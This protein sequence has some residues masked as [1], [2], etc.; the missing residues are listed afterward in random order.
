[1]PSNRTLSAVYDG[2]A[3][4][5]VRRIGI[6]DLKVALS[7]GLDDFRAKPTHMAFLCII[8]PVV[9][10]FIA[11]AVISYQSAAPLMFPIAAG[12]ALIGPLAALGLYELSRRREQGLDAG[13]SRAFDVLHSP[14]IGAIFA[15]SVLLLAL[16]VGWLYAA[17][18]IYRICFAGIQPDSLGQFVSDIFTTANGWMLIVVGNGVGFVFAVVVLSVSVVSFPLLLDRHVGVLTAVR[19]SIRA[20]VVNPKVMAIWGLIVA[21]AL[22]AG[23]LPFFVGLAV[24]IPILGH[25]TWHLYRRLVAP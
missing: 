22:L 2:P 1:M 17:R 15:L 9:G 18:Q 8:Y 12:F 25:A 10:L 19:T 7:L 24:V 13:F 11:R 21:A 14:A 16:F 6:A 4:P 5:V 3:Q 23:S 20:V